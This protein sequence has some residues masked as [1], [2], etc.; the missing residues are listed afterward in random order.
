MDQSELGVSET[1]AGLSV[2]EERAAMGLM[3]TEGEARELAQSF[4]LDNEEM[5]GQKI[6]S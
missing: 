6:G 5:W 2:A 3:E 1:P 4:H